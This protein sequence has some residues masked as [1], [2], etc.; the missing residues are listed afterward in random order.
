[1]RMRFVPVRGC[2]LM[3]VE[4][5]VSGPLFNGQAAA[6]LRGILDEARREV[7]DYGVEL[8]RGIISGSVRESRGFYA[9]QITSNLIGDRVVIDDRDVVYGPWLEGVSRRNAST[10]FSGHAQFRRAHQR[11]DR[12]A[13]KIVDRA[14]SRNIGRLG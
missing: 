7:G 4:T 8:V 10:R 6:A 2:H 12:E 9:S 13:S 1:M 5:R 14:V 11:L 3:G